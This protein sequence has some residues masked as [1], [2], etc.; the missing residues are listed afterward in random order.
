MLVQFCKYISSKIHIWKV[1]TEITNI[2]VYFITKN[3]QKVELSMIFIR[4]F[5]RKNTK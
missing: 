4:L 3:G 5:I 1:T 2:L